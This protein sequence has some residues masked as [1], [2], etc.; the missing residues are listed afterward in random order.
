MLSNLID[1]FKINIKALKVIKFNSNAE[2]VLVK[3]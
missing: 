2:I 1:D 3:N